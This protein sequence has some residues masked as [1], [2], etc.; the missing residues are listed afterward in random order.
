MFVITC[1]AQQQSKKKTCITQ[2]TLYIIF[3]SQC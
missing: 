2:F 1:T 3:G